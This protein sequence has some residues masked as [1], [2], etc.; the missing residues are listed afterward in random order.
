MVLKTFRFG[1]LD[2]GR[3]AMFISTRN[4]IVRRGLLPKAAKEAKM[5]GTMGPGAMIPAAVTVVAIAGLA[6]IVARWVRARGR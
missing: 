3:A 1:F 6:I 2:Q 4:T 5:F